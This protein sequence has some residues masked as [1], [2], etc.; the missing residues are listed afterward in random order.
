MTCRPEMD[1][2]QGWRDFLTNASEQEAHEAI[3]QALAVAS[4]YSGKHKPTNARLRMMVDV[5][6]Q[7]Y[8]ERFGHEWVPF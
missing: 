7:I 2:E 1:S 6:H 5:A 4:R 3:G 8:K